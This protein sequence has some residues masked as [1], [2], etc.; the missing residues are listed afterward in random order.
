MILLYICYLFW[1]KKAKSNKEEKWCENFFKLLL[2][3]HLAFYLWS[4]CQHTTEMLPPSK[5]LRAM[6]H[7]ETSEVPKSSF[8]ITIL[9]LIYLI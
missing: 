3:L 2:F 5:L 7:T 4:D 6:G 1:L 9:L 8:R